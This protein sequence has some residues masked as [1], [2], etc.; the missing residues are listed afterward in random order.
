MIKTLSKR[1]LLAIVSITM[2]L[3]GYSNVSFAQR[4]KR[5]IINSMIMA[6]P[7][8]SAQDCSLF[9][10]LCVG[11]NLLPYSYNSFMNRL[12]RSDFNLM[13]SNNI[14]YYGGKVFGLD[15][16]VIYIFS[17]DSKLDKKSVYYA[18]AQCAIGKDDSIASRYS[19]YY[20]IVLSKLNENFGN[21][22]IVEGITEGDYVKQYITQNNQIISYHFKQD[23]IYTMLLI[24]W[25]TPIAYFDL[26]KYDNTLTAPLVDYLGYSIIQS[27]GSCIRIQ[28][29]DR[30]NLLKFIQNSNYSYNYKAQILHRYFSALRYLQNQNASRMVI[31]SNLFPKIIQEYNEAQNRLKQKYQ[32][33]NVNSNDVMWN[34]IKSLVYTPEELKALENSGSLDILRSAVRGAS[35]NIQKNNSDKK[36]EFDGIRFNSW[37]EMDIYKKA[38]GYE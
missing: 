28:N 13:K 38:N 29:S 27:Q 22:R 33:N 31:A 4:S 24:E 23:G 12:T 8:R 1:Y 20:N 7:A 16:F 17:N 5:E 18:S 30:D 6:T 11:N 35:N 14:F 26:E 10:D 34:V 3:L 32:N 2:I 9:D 19:N 21:A 15:D 25:S 36:Y 37:E